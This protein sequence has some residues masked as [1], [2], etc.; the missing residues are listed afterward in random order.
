MTKKPFKPGDRV[1]LT[2]EAAAHFPGHPRLYTV[3]SLVG[4]KDAL[5]GTEGATYHLIAVRSAPSRPACRPTRRKLAKRNPFNPRVWH[6]HGCW[7][8]PA[9]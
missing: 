3:Q 4:Y 6:I 9:P 5:M 1:R 2:D 8:E 7:L